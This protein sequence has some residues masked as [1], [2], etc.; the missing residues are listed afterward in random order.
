M[1]TMD[2]DLNVVKIPSVEENFCISDGPRSHS[3]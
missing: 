3:F 2:L 1:L